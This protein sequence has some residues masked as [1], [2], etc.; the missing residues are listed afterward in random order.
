MKQFKADSVIID[1]RVFVELS[2]ILTSLVKL[3]EVLTVEGDDCHIEIAKS[4]INIV[5]NGLADADIKVTKR[6]KIID[7]NVAQTGSST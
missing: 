6:I 1:G 4:V 7:G 2:A 3:K 5:Y